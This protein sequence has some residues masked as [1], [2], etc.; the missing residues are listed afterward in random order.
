MIVDVNNK[1]SDCW[2]CFGIPAI[3][4]NNENT[5]MFDKFVSCKYSQTTYS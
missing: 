2:R 4:S 1:K 5:E 3:K